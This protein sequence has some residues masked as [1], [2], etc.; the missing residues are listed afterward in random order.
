MTTYYVSVDGNDSA[1]GTSTSTPFATLQRAVH[2][3]GSSASGDVAYVMDGTYDV[4][5]PLTLNA[6]NSGDTIAAYNGAAPVI[7][8]GT[9]VSGWTAGA[10]GVWTAH[11]NNVSDVQQLVVNGASQTE[12]R[13]PNYDASNPI[14]GGWLWAKDAP[15]GHDATMEMA[16]NPGDFHNGQP[17]AGEK[18]TVF[19]QLGYSSDVLTIADVDS[20]AGLIKFTSPASYDIGSGSRYFISGAQPLLDNPGEWW[21]DSS[22]HTLYYKAPAGFDGS[23]AVVANGH[24]LIDIQ[25][26]SNVA[27]KGLGFTDNPTDASSSDFT[28]SAIHV[29]GDSNHITL[30]GNSY[31]NVAKGVVVDDTSNH[32]TVSNSSFT[33]LWSSA[34]DLTPETGQNTVTNNIISHT[35]E[36]FRTGGAVE[37]TESWGN[38]ISHNTIDNVPRFGVEETNYDPNIKSGSNT[39]EYNK[40]THT[41]QQT[42]D[43]G[44]IYVYS[45]DD[46]GALGDTIRYNS[47]VDAGGLGTNGSGFMPGQYMSA[48]IY[49]DDFASNAQI[50]GNFVQGTWF[51]G[52]YL[53]GGANNNVWGNTLVD[54]NQVGIQL[55]P[56][57]D[58]PMTGT[59]VHGNIVTLPTDDGQN[60]VD[61]DPSLV[62]PHAIHDNIFVGKASQAQVGEMSLSAWKAMGGGTGTTIVAD[63]GFAN[64]GAGDYSLKDGSYALSHGYTQLPWSD[65]GATHAASAPAPTSPAPDPVSDPSPT[66]DPVSDSAPVTT[67][68]PV[69]DTAPIVTPDPVPDPTPNPKPDTHL[70]HGTDGNDVLVGNSGNDT[71]DGGPGTD[72]IHAGS[73]HEVLTGGTG[74]DRFYFDTPPDG[75]T[76]VSHITDFTPMVDEIFLSHA[77]FPTLPTGELQ[78]NAFHIGAAANS[79]TDHIL[80]DSGSGN[81][82]Y[83]SDGSGNAPQTLFANVSPNLHL[84]YNDF[85]VAAHSG[86]TPAPAAIPDPASSPS[87]S[88][89]AT[90]HT[91]H[92]THG[93]DILS[94]TSGNDTIKGGAGTDY[95]HGNGGKDVLIGGSGLDLFYFDKPADGH[96]N[97]SH[98]TDFT[99]MKDEIFLSKSAFSALP[100]GDLHAHAGA[101]HVGAAAQTPADRIIYQSHTGHLLYDSDGSGSAPAVQFASVAP[102]L[103]LTSNDFFVV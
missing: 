87:A 18:V 64:A 14:K 49:M 89:I 65:M 30:D 43:V 83:D 56:I 88:P 71:I 39:I 85:Y 91:I 70:I 78:E 10:N 76:N 36:V 37:I 103:H 35:G 66:P 42:P 28:T 98:I 23:N 99:P 94:G 45:H 102:H 3:M 54:N 40:L 22:S 13:Y 48:G 32:V 46:P 41:G 12:A 101:F 79:S 55:F 8:G 26:A 58:K 21:F 4:T 69:S 90:G 44:A 92:G 74:L 60:V 52:V 80:Y 19:S 16:Y 50:Y 20:S 38:T 67:P 5:S 57:D 15:G 73:G 75:Q 1:A 24:D 51:G 17:T 6:S 97:I 27:I 61:V 100:A 62:D 96:N 47:I 33:H 59:S 93:D 9:Q 53:H 25:N 63:P 82:F 95:I 7:S 77:A 72:Y 68:D 81:L 34:I 84:T 86:S 2:A 11:L 31:T 29:Q